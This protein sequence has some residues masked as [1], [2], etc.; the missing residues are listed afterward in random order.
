MPGRHE[1]RRERDGERVGR[2]AEELHEPLDHRDLEEHE[3]ETERGEV[4]GRRAL[5]RQ[6]APLLA[7]R[8]ERRQQEHRGVERSRSP[9]SRSSTRSPIASSG[10]FVLSGC[11]MLRDA[12]R[13]SARSARSTG[14]SSV[15][16]RDV[17]RGVRRRST[18]PAALRPRREPAHDAGAEVVAG[19]GVG[20]LVGQLARRRARNRSV[21]AGGERRALHDDR[22]EV[23][24]LA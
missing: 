3:A 4:H 23:A 18:R 22:R 1:Q 20:M 17:L 19:R 11:A 14:A 6:R 21:S 5:G 16:A 12:R 7:H 15:T 10:S 13:R 2:I 8:E 24:R 9:S